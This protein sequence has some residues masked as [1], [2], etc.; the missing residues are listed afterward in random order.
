MAAHRTDYKKLAQRLELKAY[1]PTE[2]AERIAHE[3]TS[4]LVSYFETAVSNCS[5]LKANELLHS[6]VRSAYL[7]GVIDAA[8]AMAVQQ[9]RGAEDDK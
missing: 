9:Q 7:Q 4:D 2:D 6:L 3:R 1:L 5:W 8:Q